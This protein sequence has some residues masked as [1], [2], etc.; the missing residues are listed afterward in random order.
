M[1]ETPKS[2]RL[3]WRILGGVVATLI[4]VVGFIGFLEYR[5]HATLLRFHK[6]GL[7]LNDAGDRF[8]WLEDAQAGQI[9]VESRL[10]QWLTRSLSDEVALTWLVRVRNASFFA[11]RPTAVKEAMH[12]AALLG[13]VSELGVVTNAWDA[14]GWDQIAEFQSVESMGVLTDRIDGDVSRLK[15]LPRLQ[16]LHLQAAQITEEGFEALEGLT[17]LTDLT[18]AVDGLD[19]HR[20]PALDRLRKLPHVKIDGHPRWP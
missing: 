19:K 18:L 12:S 10:P 3:D 9:I 5:R 2:R 17:Q 1:V 20:S 15:A 16:S 4:V 14:Q 7:A 11:D 13:E 6:L 8:L